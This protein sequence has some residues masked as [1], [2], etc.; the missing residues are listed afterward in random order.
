VVAV[1]LVYILR[2]KKEEWSFVY[3]VDI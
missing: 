3:C 2:S 1:S